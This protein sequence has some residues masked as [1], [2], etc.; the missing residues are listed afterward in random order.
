MTDEVGPQSALVRPVVGADSPYLAAAVEMFQAIFPE[1]GHY[2]PYLRACACQSNPAHPATFDHVWLVEADGRPAG[3]RIFSY[4][5]TRG[6]GHGAFIG[7]LEP[8]RGRGIGRWL[9]QRTLAQLC[10]D[11]ARFGGSEPQGYVAEVELPREAPDEAERR[12]RE[13][14]L[15]FHVR[16]GGMLLEVDYV[17]PPMIEG[18][19][20]IRPEQLAGVTAKPMQLVFYPLRPRPAFRRDELVGILEGLY[21]DVY[22]LEP[23]S[24]YLRRA[25]E[26]LRT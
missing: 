7:L 15:A 3:I 20:Y 25:V 5:H 4:V 16:A 12:M 23:G 14:R 24:G 18:V 1:E 26:S 22:R 2:V 9:V 8:Y 13:R 10:A 21:L 6:F 17:E 11:A 19:G